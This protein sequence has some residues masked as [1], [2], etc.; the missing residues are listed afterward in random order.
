MSTVEAIVVYQVGLLVVAVVLFHAVRGYRRAAKDYEHKLAR[1]D[2]RR[3]KPSH[4]ADYGGTFLGT[5]VQPADFSS[6]GPATVVAL[7]PRYD[8]S[9]EGSRVG[10]T[11]NPVSLN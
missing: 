1:K 10:L 8:P 4:S 2:A 6:S 3:L 5:T 7:G 11:D 9:D